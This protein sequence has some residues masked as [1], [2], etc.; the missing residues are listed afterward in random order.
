MGLCFQY[1]WTSIVCERSSVAPEPALV[2]PFLPHALV[3]SDSWAFL[4][5]SKQHGFGLMAYQ[6][7]KSGECPEGG[8]TTEIRDGSTAR[9]RKSGIQPILL[10]SKLLSPNEA[11][12]WP[13]ELEVAG[14]VWAVDRTIVYTNHATTPSV[15]RQT[16]LQSLNTDK[17]KLRLLRS[18]QYLSQ[19]NLDVRWKAGFDDVVPDALSWLRAQAFPW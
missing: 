4:G 12:H 16:S 7:R 17:L 9:I 14:L 5:T 11:N 10:V 19:F 13:T 18:S 6:V 8:A 3:G 1:S 15:V 2:L